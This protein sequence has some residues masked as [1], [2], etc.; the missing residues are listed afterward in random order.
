MRQSSVCDSQFCQGSEIKASETLITGA[1]SNESLV[2]HRTRMNNEFSGVEET[3]SKY[4]GSC[5]YEGVSKSFLTGC[6][7]REL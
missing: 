3:A 7:E 1:V 4:G 5:E 2:Y 6:L